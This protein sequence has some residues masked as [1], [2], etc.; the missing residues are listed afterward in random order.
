MLEI[1]IPCGVGWRGMREGGMRF[2]A[3]LEKVRGFFAALKEDGE[4]KQQQR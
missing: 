3:T 1:R 4:S 2:V